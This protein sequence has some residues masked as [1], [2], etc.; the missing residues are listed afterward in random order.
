MMVMMD[1]NDIGDPTRWSF[2]WD[3]VLLVQL[4]LCK[5]PERLPRA[6]NDAL[7]P[8]AVLECLIQRCIQVVLGHSR[9]WW[10][11]WIRFPLYLILPIG[12]VD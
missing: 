8:A 6:P 12:N 7:G 9:G 2:F 3:R 11:I 5:V 1:E 4:K 10:R